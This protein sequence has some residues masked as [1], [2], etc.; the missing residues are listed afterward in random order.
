ME[1]FFNIKCRYS[2]FFP[3][4]VV[5]VATVRTLKMHGGGPVVV[6]GA[7]LKNEYLDENTMLVEAGCNSSL[8]KQVVKKAKLAYSNIGFTSTI[9]G[10]CTNNGI[11]EFF[12]RIFS[13]CLVKVTEMLEK[14][15]VGGREWMILLADH[16]T[17][18]G[19]TPSVILWNLFFVTCYNVIKKLIVFVTQKKCRTDFVPLV[20][21]SAASRVV[22]PDPASTMT[23]SWLSSNTRGRPRSSSSSRLSIA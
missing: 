20:S 2:G 14:V 17:P 9:L 8:R 5:L 22:L 18:L 19:G 12:E 11:D 21:S 1:K 23:L 10:W 6:A 7:P 13:C 4:A 15:I 3:S 16:Q